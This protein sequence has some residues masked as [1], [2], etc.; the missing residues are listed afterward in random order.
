MSYIEHTLMP[1]TPEAIRG[2]KLLVLAPHPDDE[3]IGCGGLIAQHVAEGRS[4]RTVIVTDGSAAGG[5]DPAEDRSR[6]ESESIE[7]LRILGA[8][9][10]RFLGIPDRQIESRSA[11]LRNAIRAEILTF[12][13]DLIV[14]PSPVEI[15]PD[16]T[17][18]AR[19]LS[20]LIQ[21]APELLGELALCRVAFCEI[22][23]PFRPNVLVDITDVAERKY[24]AL[25]AHSS[26]TE[27]RDYESYARGLNQYRAMT[28]PSECRF[29]EGYWVTPV[30]TLHTTGWAELARTVSGSR[31]VEVIS[32]PLEVSVIIRTKDRPEQ[33]REAVE[34]VRSNSHPA[35]IIVV[36]D[37][38]VPVR[39][40]LSASSA[41]IIDHPK[42]RG[43]SEAA[44]AGVS[45]AATPFILF[46]DDD[47][48]FLEDHID[49][50]ARGWNATGS[51][52][53]YT[54]AMFSFMEADEAGGWKAGK[55]LRQYGQDY[56][57]ESL[58]IDNY[59]PLPT[60]LLTREDYL[61]LGGF[62]AG[63]DL[64]EDWDF[65]LRLRARR[66]FRRIPRITCEV[67]HFPSGQSAVMESPE[68]SPAF[69]A[70]K[71]AVWKRHAPQLDPNLI[72][73]VFERRKRDLT[74]T[75][76]AM[77][78]SA[79]RAR[80]LE[81]DLARLERD[82]E[83]LLEEL[84]KQN[85]AGFDVTAERDSFRAQ[86]EQLQSVRAE[87]DQQLESLRR[88]IADREAL[89]AATQ[90]EAAKLR[91]AAESRDETIRNLYREI[92]RLNGILETIY[93]SRTWKL[94]T[95]VEKLRGRG[96]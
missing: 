16:H 38:G 74:R 49:T 6:R 96:D 71:L 76:G 23:Q 45:A 57:P 83:T 89:H 46:L 78:E 9:A 10:P 72:A 70:A 43:R 11:D 82:K 12:R 79:G 41:T 5:G 73:N 28:L 61:A 50:L 56:D 51:I 80:H 48:L 36:N 35:S 32:E 27:L 59:I 14:V 77:V 54:D 91:Q 33:L 64:F 13:P 58:L 34:S 15:H 7:G 24:E 39:D 42:S 65:L 20:D 21:G 62:D 85:Q 18:T 44:N 75:F 30:T 19:A 87:L 90:T 92:E 3:I 55:R 17:A 69:R 66:Q 1:F 4:V 68:G 86:N 53:P 81:L 40:I 37:G 63:L 29:A 60:L 95:T 31:P 8:S 2:E 25:R 67:R 88:Q 47:D 52:S 26:Q 22:S 94:H 84:R 93:R